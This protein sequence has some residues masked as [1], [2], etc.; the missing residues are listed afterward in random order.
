VELALDAE[1]QQHLR[2]QAPQSVSHLAWSAVA[3]SFEAVLREVLARHGQFFS[4]TGKGRGPL[5]LHL[6][7]QERLAHPHLGS[8]H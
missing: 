5:D 7:A 6:P 8:L 4:A 1:R 3:D 2:A